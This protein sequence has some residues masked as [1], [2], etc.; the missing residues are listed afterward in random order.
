M[1]SAMDGRQVAQDNETNV[2]R[3]LHRFGWL[4]T[5][6]LACLVWQSMAKTP[7]KAGPSLTPPQA[8]SSAIRMAQRTLARLRQRRLVL[9]TQAPNGSLIHALSERGARVLQGLGVAASTG[10]DL[11]RDYHAAYFLHRNIANEVAISGMLEGFRAATERETAQGRWLGGMAGILGK[12]PDVLLRAGNMVWWVEVERRKN[13]QDYARLLRWLDAIW[14]NCPRPG[15]AASLADNVQLKRVV[16][17]CS[18]VIANKLAKDLQAR[19][20]SADQ[21]ASR[22]RFETSLYDFKAILFF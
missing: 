21:I 12:K 19:G 16:F 15:E 17:V 6:D 1:G 20:W 3:A 9:T 5:R 13:Q 22:I 7:A 4:R 14:S 10:K 11:V 2:L 8:T 18:M